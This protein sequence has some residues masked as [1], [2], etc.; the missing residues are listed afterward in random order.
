MLPEIGKNFIGECL[1][2]LEEK[3][4]LDK[5]TLFVS[6]ITTDEG[7]EEYKARDEFT[8]FPGE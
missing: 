7:C 8:T 6:I 3:K 2:F 4:L 5:Q 1:H